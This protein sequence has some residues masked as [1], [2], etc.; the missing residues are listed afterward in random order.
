M[1]KLKN[2]ILALE[3]NY[4]KESTKIIAVS[5]FVFLISVFLSYYLKMYYLS[6]IGLAA[7]FIVIEIFS[8]YYDKKLNQL[9]RQNET[10]FVVILNYIQTYLH[11]GFNVYKSIEATIQYASPWMQNK[12]GILITEIDSDKTIAPFINFSHSFNSPIIE[13]VMISLFLMIENGTSD[14]FILRFAPVFNQLEKDSKHKLVKQIE[15]KFDTL[16]LLPVVG[17]ALITLLIIT[18]VVGLIGGALNGI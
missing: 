13:Q 1:P 6:L 5:I 14:E 4:K 16:N 18:G 2:K 10:E 7:I 9:M 3:L 17:S 15:S 12:L 8:L 11:N